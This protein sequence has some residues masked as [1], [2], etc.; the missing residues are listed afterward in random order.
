MKVVINRCWGGFSLS[1]TAVARIAELQGRECYFFTT[2]YKQG[3]DAPMIPVTLEQVEEG[4]TRMSRMMFSAY[5]IP[6]PNE[7]FA[8]PD[9]KTWNEM[10]MEERQHNSA[11][12]EKHSFDTRPS[13][14]HDPMLVRVVEELG[15]KSWGT[16]SELRVVDIPDGT[17][18]E[19]DEYDGMETIHEKHRSWA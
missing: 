4:P 16:C 10:S 1:A 8:Y 9:N 15:E 13:E 19:I 18:Y 7:V 17:D 12:Y 5:D 2:D 3:L 6:N 11:L 14:R